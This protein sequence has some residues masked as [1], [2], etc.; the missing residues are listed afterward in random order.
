MGIIDLGDLGNVPLDQI[1]PPDSGYQQH[2]IEV[3]VGH[4]YVSL[5]NANE[6]NCYIIFRVLELMSGEYVD[7]EYYYWWP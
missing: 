3:I 7:L 2:F 4:T 1:V 6:P 5:A